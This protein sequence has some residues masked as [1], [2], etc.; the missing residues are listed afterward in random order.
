MVSVLS[1]LITL[2]TLS[3]RK[4][5]ISF[6]RYPLGLFTISSVMVWAWIYLPW[7]NRLVWITYPFLSIISKCLVY[8]SMEV[9]RLHSL[10]FLS[11]KLTA[12]DSSGFG[13]YFLFSLY[14]SAAS[15]KKNQNKLKCHKRLLYDNGK[16]HFS[17]FINIVVC[18]YVYI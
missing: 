14:T 13:D 11:I 12:S 5:L 2:L 9:S 15:L 6:C 1:H 7:L 18:G 3:A 16:E 4:R 8:Y 10:Y 17:I